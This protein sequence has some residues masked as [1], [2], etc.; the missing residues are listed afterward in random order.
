MKNLPI[1]LN[2]DSFLTLEY[3]FQ[4]G[5]AVASIVAAILLALLFR[6][7]LSPETLGKR[8]QW[9]GRIYP[10][11]Y[12]LLAPTLALVLLS[13]SYVVMHKL[14]G[15]PELLRIATILTMLWLVLRSV[16]TFTKN[17][18]IKGLITLIIIPLVIL[19]IFGLLEPIVNYLDNFALEVGS[20]KI[21]IYQVLK[22]LLALILLLWVGSIMTKSSELYIRKIKGI[23]SS[24][25]ELLIK[26]LQIAIYFL[27]FLT[28]L[29]ILGINLTTLA[30]FSGAVGVGLGFGLQKVSSNFISGLILL[31]EKSVEIG[32]L[33]QLDSGVYGYIRQMGA[34]H[35]IIETFDGKE[36]LV[37][38]EDLITQQVTNWT[39]SNRKGRTEVK[40]GVSYNSDLKL[41]QRLILESAK[42]HPKCSK[43]PAP[44]CFLTEFSDSSVNFLLY[45]WVNDVTDGRLEPQSDIM[46]SIWDKFKQ[47][48]IEIPYPQRDVHIKTLP[49]TLPL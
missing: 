4:S 5:V 42:A 37:P 17:S 39:H 34:R 14:N 20:F 46:F 3:A 35:S 1:S 19:N 28:A 45:F 26:F 33:V 23:R 6:K 38:N 13:F 30:V 40:I 9:A 7:R 44:S 41:V 32:D 36:V 8:N 31:F 2:L 12:P 11:L 27:I 10:F 29:E 43:D 49:A 16:K 21:S 48:G 24:N 18:F 15:N 25:K 47:H 22:S